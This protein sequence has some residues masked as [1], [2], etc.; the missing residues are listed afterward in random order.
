MGVYMTVVHNPAQ[1][2]AKL[3]PDDDGYVFYS[4]TTENVIT[5]NTSLQYCM[6]N[7][8]FCIILLIFMCDDFS[9]DHT[10]RSA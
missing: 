7:L 10:D 3:S 9:T 8:T 5:C 4:S 6:Y 1:L 2:R